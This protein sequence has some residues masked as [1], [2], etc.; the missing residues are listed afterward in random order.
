MKDQA[1]IVL[2]AGRG[3]GRTICHALSD[4]FKC[5]ILAGR[6]RENLEVTFS[7]LKS[8]AADPDV[9]LLVRLVDLTD[10]D[11][12]AGFV[13]SLKDLAIPVRALINTAAGF[14]RG[15]FCDQSF[16]SADSLISANY[17]G[18]VLL[19][20]KLLQ[21][22]VRSELIDII[23]VTNVNSSTTLDSS[24]SSAMHTSSKAA[25][26]IFSRVA[27]RELVADGVRLTVLAPGTFARDGRKGISHESIAHIVEFLLTL[28]DDVWIESIGRKYGTTGS[29]LYY[30]G[31][32]PG[33][34]FPPV[35]ADYY[36]VIA[37]PHINQRL[38]RR[39]GREREY[40]I[41]SDGYTQKATHSGS[42]LFR[43]RRNARV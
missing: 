5:L 39:T 20:S 30:S 42:C 22:N 43:Q 41:C 19:T 23:H 31:V 40:N 17:T 18:P 10:N 29:S 3:L 7:E 14:Y 27:G 8:K 32:W 12:I 38:I 26:N 35:I 15:R 2:G 4:K 33:G 36:P 9:E 1:A 16:E 37:E 6:S 13:E 21:E 34:V 24:R 25:L 28:P 11:S